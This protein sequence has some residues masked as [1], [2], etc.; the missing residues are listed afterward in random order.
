MF[1]KKA[2]TIREQINLLRERGLMYYIRRLCRALSTKHKLLQ[3]V[4]V[5]RSNQKLLCASQPVKS[6]H[7]ILHN[8]SSK[9]P[10][11]VFAKFVD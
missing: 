6:L 11:S 4:T 10:Y 8:L 5:N 3:L 2:L 1:D 9:L 7:L